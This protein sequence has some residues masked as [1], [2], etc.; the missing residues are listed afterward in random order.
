MG[1]FACKDALCAE[2]VLNSVVYRLD[3]N[4]KLLMKNKGKKQR[5]EGFLNDI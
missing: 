1:M 4:L 2:N 5:H 3:K